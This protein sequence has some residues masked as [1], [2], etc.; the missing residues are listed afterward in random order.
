MKNAAPRRLLWLQKLQVTESLNAGDTLLVVGYSDSVDHTIGPV[1]VDGVRDKMEQQL[2]GLR[3]GGGGI[4][5]YESLDYT[6]NLL[7][8]IPE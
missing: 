1:E 6:L 2:Y 8:G 7:A 5:V 4:F 3:A